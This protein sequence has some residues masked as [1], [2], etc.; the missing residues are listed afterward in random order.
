MG[1]EREGGGGREGMESEG[2]DGG[3]RRVR[4]EMR[5]WV[6]RGREV[7]MRVREGEEIINFKLEIISKC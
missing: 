4:R 7:I 3:R 2:G 6:R 5:R 1:E